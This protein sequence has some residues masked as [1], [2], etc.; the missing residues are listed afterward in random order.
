MTGVVDG[1]APKSLPLIL[2]RELAVNLSTAMFLLDSG[3]T[4]VFFNDAAEQLLGRPFAELGE[5]SAAEFGG[6]LQLAEP[7]GTPLRRRDS[8]AGVAFLERRPAHRVLLATAYDGTRRLVE[9]T[10]YPLLG[11]GDEMHGVVNVFWAG[12]VVAEGDA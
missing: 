12:S 9:S 6:V 11:S 10:A 2:A 7:D 3:G 1:G 5:I 8:P 4:L